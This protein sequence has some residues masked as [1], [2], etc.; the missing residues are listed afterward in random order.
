MKIPSIKFI[1]DRKHKASNDRK[2]VVELRITHDGKRKY[3][4]TGVT[5]YPGQWDD[6]DE[7][8]NH[9]CVDCNEMNAILIKMKQQAL[10]VVGKMMDEDSVDI[11][12]IPVML[13]ANVVDMT[14][15]RY[16]RDRM[17][18]RQVSDYTK[19][20]YHVFYSRF[21]EWGKMTLFSQ[22]SERGI[23]D[24]DEYLHAFRWKEK[25]GRNNDVVRQYS[26]ATIG[27]MHKNLKVFIADAVV[28]GYLKEN[29]YVAKRIKIDKGGTRIDR[30]LTVEEVGAVERA[31]MPTKA[32]EES[33]DLFLVQ[34]YS[35]LSFVD[36]MSYDFAQCRNANDYAVFSGL[37]SKTKTLFSFVLTPKTKAILEHYDY[38][39]PKLPNQ[40]YNMRIKIIMDAAGIDKSVSS[41]DAR[42]SCGSILLNA[43][44]PISVVSRILGHSSI[45]QTEQAY[46]RLLDDTIAEEIRKRI[47]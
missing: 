1:F 26:Q 41:H 15:D 33:R 17:R 39:L 38:K 11:D 9:R 46:A 7:C 44:V 10:K 29:P 30:F 16:I 32:L 25:D 3:A 18:K 42:R 24:W 28:D 21:S 45:R 27:S 20:A 47:R 5:C 35:G 4:S 40:K 2:G 23:R 12:I 19:K 6:K 13:K 14:F 31:K 36:L 43:G 8:V 37:R 34:V 22:V